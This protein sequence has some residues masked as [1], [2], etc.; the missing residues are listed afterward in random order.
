MKGEGKLGI[1]FSGITFMAIGVDN[2]DGII[3]ACKIVHN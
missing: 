1:G 2:I 3:D